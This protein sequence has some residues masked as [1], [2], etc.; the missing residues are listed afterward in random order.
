MQPELSAEPTHH[1]VII[2]GGGQAG[3]SVAYELRQRGIDHVIFEAQRAGHAWRDKRWDSFCL[4]TPNWQCQLPGFPY[5]GNEPD[6]FM[7]KDEIVAYLDAYLA[8]SRPPLREGVRVTRVVQK[9]DGAG[10]RRFFVSTSR[11][12][13]SADQVVIAAGNYHVPKI[14]TMA[15]QLPPE[16][17]QLHA[18]EYRNAAAL[19]E[20]AVL[21]VG[22]GQSGCQI[23]EDLQLEGRQ[24]HLCVGSA[25]RV[26]RRY[27]NRDVV[28]WLHDMGHYD[29]PVDKHPLKQGV[30]AKANHYVTGRD[31]GRDIDLRAFA[32]K[33]M[34]LHGRLL[35]IAS[36]TLTFA[37][38]LKKNLDN[39][40][41]VSESIKRSIDD[42]IARAGSDA[43][44]EPPYVPVW[45]PGPTARELDCS[46]A[47]ITSVIWS[48]G[49]RADFGFIE[50]PAFDADGSPVHE[51]GITQVAGLY[52]IGLPWLYT[53]GSGRFSG[54]ARDAAYLVDHIGKGRARK[55]VAQ[56]SVA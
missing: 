33:G 43:P 24:V 2:V 29:L 21:V 34:Q 32:K 26:A 9:S 45:Q 12:E 7:K 11:G 4:V 49:Y 55:H 3:L 48:M 14:P 47:N 30:R 50:L 1:T 27:R 19:P 44:S 8:F 10:R 40:D 28:A 36:G 5:Q 46:A 54:V 37:D 42:Y 16:L 53:W 22:T 51:R 23:A 35:G 52:F 31:G 38:D 17:V 6:G 39:A 20:G 18:S 25:P 15:S 13:F 56:E 41:A